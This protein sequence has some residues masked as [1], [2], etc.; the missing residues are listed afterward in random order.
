MNIINLS[1][2]SESTRVYLETSLR[3]L[4]NELSSESLIES[5]DLIACWLKRQ[6]FHTVDI[7]KLNVYFDRFLLTPYPKTV[8]TFVDF[9]ESRMI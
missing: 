4:Q 9:V 7:D 6:S 2:L 8:G 5:Q 3:V 1:D